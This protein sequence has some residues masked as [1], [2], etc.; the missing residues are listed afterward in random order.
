MRDFSRALRNRVA[1][2]GFRV[3]FVTH[4]EARAFVRV[5]KKQTR[6]AETTNEAYAAA[7]HAVLS[8]ATGA[9]AKLPA[10]NPAK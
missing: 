1:V 9:F 7:A 3:V 4:N 10:A 6:V 8:Q 5:S 2:S